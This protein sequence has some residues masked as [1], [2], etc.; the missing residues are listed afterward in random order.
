MNRSLS[1]ISLVIGI[2]VSAGAVMA[3]EEGWR[4]HAAADNSDIIGVHVSGK[5]TNVAEGELLEVELRLIDEGTFPE[6][7]HANP[8]GDFD[9]ESIM[10]I[11]IF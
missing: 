5:I 3:Q 2:T 8:A 6:R 1:I 9:L 11:N 7:I 10:K 4:P